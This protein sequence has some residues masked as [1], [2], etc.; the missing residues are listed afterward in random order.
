MIRARRWLTSIAAFALALGA[1]AQ[2]YPSNP[3]KFVVPFPPGSQTDQVARLVGAE[4]Q[5]E[6]G[7]AIVIDNR[8]GAQ[9]GIGAEYVAKSPP[10]GYTLFVTTGGVQA[11]NASL[12][13][14]LNYDPV[15]DFTAVA[16]I[17]TSCL[18]LMVRPDFPARTFPDFVARAKAEPG[19]FSGG[20]GSPGAQIALAMIKSASALPITEVPYK[21]IPQAIIDLLG[22]SIAFTFVD[23]GNAIAQERSGKLRGLAVTC[24]TRTALTPEIPTLSEELRGDYDVTSWFGVVAP[25]A[26]PASAV[27]RMQDAILKV[28]SNV[29]VRTRLA[30]IGTEA[31]PMDAPTFGR[32]IQKE[33]ESWARLTKLAGIQPE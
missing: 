26:T 31:A 21:G 18:V 1:H 23:T 4:L 13:K 10:D 14:K 8:P 2:T 30:A 6:L 12:F 5:V 11:A 27:I 17:S 33:V 29:A 20:Y 3:V 7:Q 28:V 22:G 19:K 9:G 16:R 15:R 25:A 24:G 32:F